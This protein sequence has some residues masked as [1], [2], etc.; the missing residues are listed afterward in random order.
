MNFKT[1]SIQTSIKVKFSQFNYDWQT[2][3][4]NPSN[5]HDNT[6]IFMECVGECEN[7]Y[8]N[9]NSTPTVNHIRICEDINYDNVKV[10]KTVGVV[11]WE[12]REDDVVN[13][14]KGFPDKSRRR[15]D[16][17]F[18]VLN[19]AIKSHVDILVFPEVS[20]PVEWFPLLV[21][22]SARNNIMIIGGLEYLLAPPIKCEK[23]ENCDSG[24]MAY[25]MMFTIIPIMKKYYRAAIPLLRKKNYYSPGEL[26]LIRGFH[27]HVPDI[28]SEY[29]LVQWRKV[30]FSTYNCFELSN[31]SDRAVFK[32]KVDFIAAIEYNRDI[33]YFSNI[34][35]SWSR[36]L[37]CFIIQSNPAHY[38][39][40]RIVKPSSKDTKDIVRVKGGKH[41]VVMVA[42]LSIEKLRN[43]N[44][45][46]HNLQLSDN[47][48]SH[49]FKPTPAQFEWDW[50][51][52]RI[53]N[54]SITD[55]SWTSKVKK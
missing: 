9:I 50:V 39:D 2:L 52:R 36:D 7:A 44:R 15:R 34:T 3:F 55:E 51:E 20:I 37:H 29:H 6:D 47:S 17:L 53:R 30:Y 54:E 27:L 40:S 11:N 18:E 10:D 24:R 38:G 28:P 46:D 35:E 42:D 8:R 32:S 33:S 43:F 25:N 5:N 14:L 4:T 31:I 1:V 19:S 26:E 16:N 22:Q 41:P 23:W 48:S 45:R 13:S 12:V 49:G 21:E